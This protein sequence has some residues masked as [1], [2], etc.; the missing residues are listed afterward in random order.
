FPALP[1]SLS[2]YRLKPY[3]YGKI[4]SMHRNHEWAS[5]HFFVKIDVTARRDGMVERGAALFHDPPNLL[6]LY[7]QG[8]IIK[9]HGLIDRPPQS[10]GVKYLEKKTVA[11][12]LLHLHLLHRVVNP[13]RVMGHRQ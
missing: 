9:N 4:R 5:Q 12:V 8:K 6:L 10:F 7:L 13:S 2:T 11:P 1:Y 3:F